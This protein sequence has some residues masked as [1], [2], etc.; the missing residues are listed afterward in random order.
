M[1]ESSKPMPRK[2]ETPDAARR[3]Q[4]KA[5]LQWGWRVAILLLIAYTLAKYF[6][7]PLPF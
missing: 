5:Q 3:K 4:Q 6:K 7:L 1:H 2:Q